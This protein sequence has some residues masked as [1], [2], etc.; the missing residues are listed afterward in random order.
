MLKLFPYNVD[1]WVLIKSRR[2]YAV[3][4]GG[5]QSLQGAEN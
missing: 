1:I 2:R 3:A 5:A 4:G